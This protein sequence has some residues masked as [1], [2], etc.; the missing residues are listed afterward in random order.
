MGFINIQKSVGKGG[1]GQGK[2]D[3]IEITKGNYF[4]EGVINCVEGS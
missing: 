4:K 3:V 2:C 1:A